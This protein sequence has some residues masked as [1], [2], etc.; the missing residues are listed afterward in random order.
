MRG[1]RG[2]AW[3]LTLGMLIAGLAVPGTA[4][5]HL[6]RPSYWPD[7][8]PDTSVNPPAGGAVP[9]I[10]SLQSAVTGAGPGRV[11]VVCQG[12]RGAASL[13]LATQSIREA[14]A[15]GF[16]IRPS[17]PITRYSRS[18]AR[19]MQRIN[20]RLRARCRYSSIQRAVNDSGNNDR[21]VIMPGV[22][23]EPESRSRPMNDP[24]CKP[25]LLQKDASG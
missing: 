23:T 11:R 2:N 19:R 9:K 18:T 17:Q 15:Q 1:Q 21:V 24:R 7:P 13:R 20:E 14:R 16:R 4:A 8:A 3:R 6:E 22:Y 10:R 12:R 25:S 5:A